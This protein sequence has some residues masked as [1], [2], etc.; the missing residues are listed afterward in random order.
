MKHIRRYLAL[1]MI[2]ACTSTMI[3]TDTFA[4]GD[5]SFE[6]GR[7]DQEEYLEEENSSSYE[8]E[9]STSNQTDGGQEGDSNGGSQSNTS[10]ESKETNNSSTDSQSN[11][12]DNKDT[13]EESQENSSEGSTSK[14]EMKWP[15]APNFNAES[16]ILLDA[17]SGIIL[18]SKKMDEVVHPSGLTKLMTAMLLVEKLQLTDSITFTKEGIAMVT[19]ES[20]NLNTKL[21][22]TLTVEQCLY[23][24]L[25]ESANDIAVQVAVQIA[26]SE[27]KFVELMNARAKELECTYTTFSNATGLPSD[28]HTSTAHDMALI[29]AAAFGHESLAKAASASSYTIPPTNMTSEARE[30]TNTHPLSGEYTG[31]LGGKSGHTFTTGSFIASVVEKDKMRLV[32]VITKGEKETTKKD[33]TTLF[34][35][36]YENFEKIP[37]LTILTDVKGAEGIVPKGTTLS[38]LE[39]LELP[40]EATNTMILRYYYGDMVVGK[41]DMTMD[42]WKRE[43]G[44]E[45]IEP[46]EITSEEIVE[47]TID[48]KLEK[49]PQQIEKLK[50]ILI[51]SMLAL[52]G[53][54]VLVIIIF[55]IVSLKKK[56]S[57]KK[58]R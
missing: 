13:T 46:K 1:I 17:N 15:E 53:L 42:E 28:K 14:G 58:K 41:I 21:G 7:Y 40:D 9:E 23:A 35:W 34:D 32:S 26:G 36:A 47:E 6:G 29:C 20:G 31:F 8:G 57:A 22:E 52:A 12:T 51:V 16:G 18:A 44:Q 33:V 2:V 30:L 50:N 45:S 38:Q 24:L 37:L 5:D 4:T 19:D 49:D 11:R 3:K 39:K 54:A 25:F 27:E 43:N 48:E 55:A 56:K 10:E